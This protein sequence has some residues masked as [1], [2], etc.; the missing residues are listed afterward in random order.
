MRDGIR[1]RTNS[2]EIEIPVLVRLQSPTII[3]LLPIRILRIIMSRLIRLPNL[4]HS[5]LH[6]PPLL[7]RNPALDKTPLLIPDLT[8]NRVAQFH[9]RGILREKGPEDGVFRGA[10]GFWVVEGVDEDRK[11]EDVRKEYEFLAG[12]GADLPGCG[13]ELQGCHPFFG[14]EGCFAGEIVE[15]L[16]E[17]V[18]EEAETVV[19]ACPTSA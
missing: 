18:D 4:N 10:L 16:G 2:L 11:T 3:R 7:I 14:C 1:N 8:H 17:F 13:E 5:S 15:M 12:V 9:V 19:G 6:R